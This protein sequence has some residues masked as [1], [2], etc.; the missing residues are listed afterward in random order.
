MS[1]TQTPLIA[2]THCDTVHRRVAMQEAAQARCVRCETVLYRGSRWQVGHWQAVVL[3]VLI[4]FLIA[5]GFP[6]VSLSL[7]GQTVQ[8]TFPDALLLIWQQGYWELS[9]LAGL[10]GFWLP[11]FQLLFQLWALRCIAARRRPNDF[12]LGLRVLRHLQHWSMTSVLFLGIVVAIVKFSGF[13]DLHLKVGI[14]AFLL[15]C[16][17]LTALS[18]IDHM[19]L[20]LWAE[21]AGMVMTT[22]TLQSNQEHCACESCGLVQAL[23]PSHCLR[24]H[25]TL[26][27]RR[28]NARARSLAF[29][30]TAI[31]LYIPAN[32]LPMM[33]LR[34][35]VMAGEHTIIGGVIQLWE[36]GSWDL[37]LIVFVASVVVPITKIL[38]LSVLN[39]QSRWRGDRIQQQRNRLYDMVELIGQWSML[40]VFVVVLMAALANF[41]GVSQIIP[42]PAAISFGLVVVLTMLA[43]ESY[44]PRSA[45]DQSKRGQVTV[46]TVSL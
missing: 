26:H 18:R 44:D 28:P 6:I 22:P 4:L 2:C 20:W 8:P 30:A 19:R 29:L 41:P 40:D 33:E 32:V 21:D 25:A 45:W 11:L 14:Y 16:F 43:A 17:L 27:K 42:G 10:V 38:A 39:L 34:S 7:A 46:S 36:L 3:A 5:N 23:G 13:G 1:T 37:A 12:A 35:L 24:C 15:L 9:V 31:V